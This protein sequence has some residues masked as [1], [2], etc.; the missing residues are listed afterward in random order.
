MA[1]TSGRQLD[2]ERDLPPLLD[3]VSRARASGLHAFLHRGGLQWLLRRLG[4]A[5]FSP[6]QWHAA[7][8][9]TG[10][11]VSDGGAVIVQPALPDVDR[12]LWLLGQAKDELRGGGGAIELCAWDGDD[13]LVA[14]LRSRGY[15]RS[16]RSA[17][18]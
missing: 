12:R 9:L 11:V 18:S 15:R 16:G 5:S 14:A 17:R 13:E 7:G 4:G 1:Q 6:R 8:A 2:R 10:V 3:L